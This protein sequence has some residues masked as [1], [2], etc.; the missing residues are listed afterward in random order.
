MNPFSQ[1]IAAELKLL[2]QRVDS[3]RRRIRCG[4]LFVVLRTNPAVSPGINTVLRPEMFGRTRSGLARFCFS[5]SV[6]DDLEPDLHK[7]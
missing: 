6:D 2:S 1:P 4:E 5:I 3:P 7:V